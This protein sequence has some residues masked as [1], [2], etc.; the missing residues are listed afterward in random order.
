M[1]QQMEYNGLCCPT[2]NLQWVPDTGGRF[3]LVCQGCAVVW[4]QSNP[5]DGRMACPDPVHHDEDELN[6]IINER[7]QA[8]AERLV[9]E[10]ENHRTWEDG[11]GNEGPVYPWNMEDDEPEETPERVYQLAW[12]QLVQSIDAK[13]SWGKNA[14][15]D[16]FLKCLTEADPGPG[17]PEDTSAVELPGVDQQ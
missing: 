5:E 2:P 6:R 4:E 3:S 16:L 15:K 12:L 17:E 9:A 14:L 1:T 13:T 10:Q 7:A 11:A 8:L